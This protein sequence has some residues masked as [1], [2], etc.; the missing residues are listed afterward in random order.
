MA[1]YTPKAL[2]PINQLTAT[3]GTSVYTQ[4][5]SVTSILRT[6][7]LQ[8]AASGRTATVSIGADASATRILDAFPLTQYV[9]TV[10]NGWWVINSGAGGAH[11]I[12]AN[13]DAGTAVNLIISGYEYQ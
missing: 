6:V 9:P 3:P 12:D 4:P 1:T 11:A 2:V 5:A 10:Y 13:A 7:Y 8:T